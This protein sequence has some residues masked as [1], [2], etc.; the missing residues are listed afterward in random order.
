MQEVELAISRE[1]L[2]MFRFWSMERNSHWN[3]CLVNWFEQISEGWR[4]CSRLYIGLYLT[5]KNSILLK[6]IFQCKYESHVWL[7]KDGFVWRQKSAF[8]FHIKPEYDHSLTCNVSYY[9]HAQYDLK[10]TLSWVLRR[11]GWRI[12]LMKPLITQSKNTGVLHRD[13]I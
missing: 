9:H 11:Q 2:E 3:Q 5:S 10:R 4:C 8:F 13:S 1:Q 6:S 7:E 12:T